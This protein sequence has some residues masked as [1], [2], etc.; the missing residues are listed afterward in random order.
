M[1]RLALL[2]LVTALGATACLGGSSTAPASHGEDS[3]A[4]GV[5]PAGSLRL[6]VRILPGRCALGIETPRCKTATAVV[7]HYSLTCGPAGGSMPNPARACAAIADYLQQDHRGGCSAALSGPGSTADVT[8]TFA[9]RP[10]S[11]KLA[12]ANSWCGR[13]PRVLRDLWIL[14]TLPCSADND[15]LREAGADL[16]MAIGCVAHG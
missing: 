3:T 8:G 12:T 11:L 1:H 2:L 7:R 14:S 4:N 9:H 16:A 13:T 6:A 10:F 5:V 15:V